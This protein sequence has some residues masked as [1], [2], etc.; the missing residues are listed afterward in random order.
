MEG[1]WFKIE[2]LIRCYRVKDGR[3]K[4]CTECAMKEAMKELPACEG[5]AQELVKK[6]LDPLREAYGAKIICNSGYRCSHHNKNVGSKPSSQHRTASAADITAGSP[7]ENLK[8]A[9]LI[10][11]L[12]KFD[13]MILY[14]Q[15]VHVSWKRQGGNR[16]QIL[17][18]TATGYSAV[19]AKEVLQ[20]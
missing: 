19:S 15:F 16:C 10:V 4:D 12:G 6:V 1:K 20:G 7:E 17:R 14:P 8:L 2:E 3:C 18:K 13:Q 5:N 11:E 9:K